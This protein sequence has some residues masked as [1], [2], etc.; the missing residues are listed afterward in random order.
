MPTHTPVT[1]SGVY[2]MVQLSRKSFV[3]PVF[4]ATWK[5]RFRSE[6]RPNIQERASLSERID[7][8][9]KAC[10]ARITC[11]GAGGWYS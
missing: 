2:P 6:L 4:A 8:I 10:S 5:G 3:V 1:R 11:S 9:R 7:E